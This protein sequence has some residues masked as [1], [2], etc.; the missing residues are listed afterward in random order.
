MRRFFGL[1]GE[2]A[3]TVLRLYAGKAEENG[4]AE[5]APRPSSFGNR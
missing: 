1:A 3:A 2:G 5:P 4:E